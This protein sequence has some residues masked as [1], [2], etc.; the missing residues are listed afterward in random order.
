MCFDC[1]MLRT[2]FGASVAQLSM[3]PLEQHP[4]ELLLLTLPTFAIAGW[5]C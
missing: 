3:F 5:L 4:V 1:W 2:L